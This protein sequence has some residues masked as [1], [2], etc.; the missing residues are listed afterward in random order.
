[1]S[2]SSDGKTVAI[3]A[4]YNDGNGSDSGH[5]R[6]YELVLD[7]SVTPSLSLQPSASVSFV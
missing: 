2:L 5:V 7:C 6:V 1:M 3:G 4:R